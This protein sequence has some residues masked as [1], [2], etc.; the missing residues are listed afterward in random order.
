MYLQLIATYLPV[1][2]KPHCQKTCFRAYAR[3]LISLRCSQEETCSL[4]NY[5]VAYEETQSNRVSDF[6]D[7]VC[8]LF[9]KAILF[10]LA[11]LA[12][13]SA[14]SEDSDQTVRMHSLIWIYTGRICSMVCFLTRLIYA[15]LI[16][17]SARSQSIQSPSKS[18]NG[19]KPHYYSEP[20]LRGQ[21]LFP[22]TLPLNEFAV[23]QNT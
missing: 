10:D 8:S 15:R 14:L 19:F 20:L 16:E 5:G 3:N 7:F 1:K 13:Q 17:Y 21:H 2:F 6:R 12:I 23:V 22:N 18:Q 11:S 9:L 4:A